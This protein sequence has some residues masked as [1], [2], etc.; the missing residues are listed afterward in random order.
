MAK[1]RVHT[2]V[3]LQTGIMLSTRS[4]LSDLNAEEIEAFI[5]KAKEINFKYGSDEFI[6][7]FT[8]LRYLA[9]IDNKIHATELGVLLFGKYPQIFFP[10]A[11]VRATIKT[12][13]RGCASSVRV[14]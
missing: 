13:G 11:V 3:S 9:N 5:D 14:I 6:N 7:V 1:L 4:L 2:E 12:A 8:Q 10:Q